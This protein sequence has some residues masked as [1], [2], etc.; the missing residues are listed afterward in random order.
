MENI[1]IWIIDRVLDLGSQFG[2]FPCSGTLV[3]QVMNVWIPVR[4]LI[5]VLIIVLIV[6]FVIIDVTM[7]FPVIRIFPGF[8]TTPDGI[9]GV[10]ATKELCLQNQCPRPY[11]DLGCP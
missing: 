1:S 2:Q 6:V 10:H 4:I 11:G 5:F 9:S 8:R 3:F 7:L